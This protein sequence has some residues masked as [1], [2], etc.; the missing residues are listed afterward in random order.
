M[1]IREA[2]PDL[3]ADLEALFG[4]RGACG[5]CWCMVWRRRRSEFE[6][7]KGEGNR[8]ALQ[9][10]VLSGATPGLI[11]YHQEE[12]VGWVSVAPR[13]EFLTLANSRIWKRV[14]DEPVWSITC[15]FI[16][17]DFRRQGL[18]VELIQAAAAFARR[19]GAKILEGYATQASSAMPGPFVWTGLANAFRKAGFSV[20]AERSPRRQLLRLS[21]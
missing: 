11:A 13:T 2:T 17:K 7:N 3:W 15:F 20:A 1:E 19:R 9:Q 4:A 5:G 6:R 16:R 21:L 18:T 8:A 12:P 14:D 10:L